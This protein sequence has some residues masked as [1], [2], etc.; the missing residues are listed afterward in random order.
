MNKTIDKIHEWIG[1]TEDVDNLTAEQA[2]KLLKWLEENQF[3][4][5]VNEN[6]DKLIEFFNQLISK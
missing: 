1:Y 2:E 5:E 6:W 4:G 3:D